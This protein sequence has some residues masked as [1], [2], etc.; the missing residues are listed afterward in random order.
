MSDTTLVALGVVELAGLIGLFVLIR[1]GAQ[2]RAAGKARPSRLAR[3]STALLALLVVVGFPAWMILSIV[4]PTFLTERRHEELIAS[5][6]AATATI[7][8]IEETGTVINRRPEVRVL[9]TVEPR[10]A[11]PFDSQSTWVFSVSD[12]QTYRVGTKVKVFFDPEDHQTVA[13]VGLAPSG[14]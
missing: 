1:R 5:G 6:T 2:R 3:V 14:E 8:H 7:H 9:L 11:P 10:G 4:N 12:T 13:V